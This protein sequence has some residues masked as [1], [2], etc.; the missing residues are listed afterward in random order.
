MRGGILLLGAFSFFVAF[1]AQAEIAADQNLPD[2]SEQTPVFVAGVESGG[3]DAGH[4]YAAQTSGCRLWDL[5]V[6]D[7]HCREI[8]PNWCACAYL[9][10]ETCDSIWCEYGGEG[11]ACCTG[12]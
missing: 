7:A 9:E 11:C 8:Y 10:G 1:V 3:A 4:L 5:E 6:C 2:W 12:P